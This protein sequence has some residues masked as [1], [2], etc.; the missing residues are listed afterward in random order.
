GGPG[1][2]TW[3]PGDPARVA[4]A[5][6][7]KRATDPPRGM[8]GSSNNGRVIYRAG[9]NRFGGAMQL[10]LRGG[11]IR[12]PVVFFSP[13]PPF[14]VIHYP[15]LGSGSMLRRLAVGGAGSADAPKTEMLVYLK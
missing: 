6:P 10:G 15:Y 9:A 12:S 7:A 2:F 3:C 8:G 13:N 5:P 11:G 1:S 4:M 14:R